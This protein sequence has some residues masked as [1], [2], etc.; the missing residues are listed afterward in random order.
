MI[1]QHIVKPAD[2]Y[3]YNDTPARLT[4]NIK[5]WTF[6]SHIYMVITSYKYLRQGETCRKDRE[7]DCTNQNVLSRDS[8]HM[9]MS[10]KLACDG[11]PNCGQ[12]YLPNM[13]ETC[14]EVRIVS[15]MLILPPYMIAHH[16]SFYITISIWFQ[17]HRSSVAL[18]LV[19]Y[20]LLALVLL[21]FL[22]LLGCFIIKKQFYDN[23]G[24]SI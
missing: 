24:E 5:D 11:M 12:D 9:C 20:T 14:F 13:D 2:L 16:V 17:I 1:F 6:D 3:S 8:D 15:Y 23:N 21:L 10:M 19:S 18:P 4:I 22:G 7:F